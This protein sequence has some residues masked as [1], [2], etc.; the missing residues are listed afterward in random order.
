MT[1]RELSNV[2]AELDR[3]SSHLE[4]ERRGRGLKFLRAFHAAVAQ[5]RQFPQIYSLADDGLP[6][7]EVR[8]AILERFDYRVVYLVRPDE[9]VLLTVA[10]TSRRPEHWHRRLADPAL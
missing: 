3:I 5:I 4:S 8:N 10:H 6:P 2:A 9:V 7:H 1:V